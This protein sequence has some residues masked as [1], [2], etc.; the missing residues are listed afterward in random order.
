M[1]ESTVRSQYFHRSL[2]TLS[3]LVSAG[4]LLGASMAQAASVTLNEWDIY[5]YPQQTEAVDQ[6]IKAFQQKNP[7]I[8]IQRSVHSFEDTRIPLK[9]A[10]TAGDG[11]QIAQ[12]NQ[13]GG[14][15]GSLVKDKLLWP[16]DDYAKTYGWTTRFPDSILKRN[17]WSD[18]QDFGSGKLYGVASL[19][20]MVGLYYNKALL[21]KAGIA[22]PKTL[23]ELEQA[24]E[25]LKAQGTAPMMLGLLDG[26]MGQQ[27]L[28]TLWEAQIESSDRKKLDDLIYD[29]GGTFKD[30]K[31]VKAANMM[32]S[33]NDKGYFFPGFQ[34]IGHDDAATLFQNGQAA[35]LVSGTWYLGQFKDNKDIHFAAMP[36]GEGVQHAL[37][38]G[39]TD[40]AFSITSTAKSKEQQDAAAKFIDYIVSDEMANRWLKVGFLPASASKNAQIPSDNP[41]LAET[42]QVWV[43]LNE[44]DGLGHYVDWA[45][46]TMNAE[47]NQ[48]VQLLLA[49]RQTADQMVTNFDNNYQR[50]LKTLK[51]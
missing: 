8:V 27:L 32:K 19:G 24:M 14:D 40:L 23:P 7:G 41:L 5:N 18:T 37:M 45:T 9:L 30:D 20:E 43:T 2:R 12:V 25:K 6:A 44:H 28:S 1:C 48:N 47:L 51:H 10:L 42:Y 21:D 16:L 26:N 33:W 3:R 4:V 50:Y 49:G 17:R 11:P 35:F 13:G 34:G 46:P 15:M 39:G 38:V 36:M 22:V 31:L 29:V